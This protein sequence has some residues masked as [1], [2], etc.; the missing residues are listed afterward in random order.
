MT[1]IVV[2]K[3][4]G[5]VTIAGDSLTTFG[6]TRLT[7]EYDAAYDKIQRFGESYFGIAGSAA[8]H[9]VIENIFHKR[10][11][12]SFGSKAEVFESFNKIHP[13]LKDEHFLNPKEEEDDPYESSQLTA[14]I[15]NKTGIYAVYSMREVFEFNRFWAIGS[16]R[17]FA[18]G[19]MYAAYERLESAEQVARMG[20]EAGC[21]FDSGSSLPMT[22][23]SVQIDKT[24]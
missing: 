10:T 1:T 6:S 4:N 2:V 18:L 22:V 14:V 16:G 8:H 12:L 21:E 24:G 9:L 23:Y 7:P 15:A 17:E 19:A 3:K 13:Q 11:D 20:V 5:I